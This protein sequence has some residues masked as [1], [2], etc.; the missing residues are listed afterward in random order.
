MMTDV[1]DLYEEQLSQYKVTLKHP[2]VVVH[3][4]PLEGTTETLGTITVYDDEGK[5][6]DKALPL[7]KFLEIVDL[8]ETSMIY[9]TDGERFKVL[10]WKPNQKVM[11][12]LFSKRIH[13]FFFLNEDNVLDFMRRLSE[14]YREKGIEAKLIIVYG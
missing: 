1:L 12:F 8:V 6:S 2:G 3:L 4:Y 11:D 5:K 7:D 13:R 14:G 9:A 10:G